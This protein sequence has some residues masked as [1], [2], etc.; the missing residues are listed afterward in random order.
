MNKKVGSESAIEGGD[1]KLEREHRL[2]GIK[3]G[4]NL[5]LRSP[6]Y[7]CRHKTNC[8]FC[9]GPSL[10]PLICVRSL[11]SNFTS[12]CKNIQLQFVVTVV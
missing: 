11:E 7:F 10:S 3:D 1:E 2:P 6:L 4:D 12:S 9:L 8:T 5:F